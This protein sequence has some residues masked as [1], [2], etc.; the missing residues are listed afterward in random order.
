[1]TPEQR[2]FVERCKNLRIIVDS[3]DSRWEIITIL[4][5]LGMVKLEWMPSARAANGKSML[6][7]ARIHP[8]DKA[9][10]VLAEPLA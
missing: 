8:T 1:M 6:P 10:A 2:D 7:S 3:K 9:L 5:K 4:Q